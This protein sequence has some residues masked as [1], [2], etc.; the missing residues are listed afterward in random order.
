MNN[1]N[2]T[3]N[4]IKQD[5][6]KERKIIIRVAILFFLLLL[7]SVVLTALV[8]FSFTVNTFFPTPEEKLSDIEI[9]KTVF[10]EHAYFIPDYDEMDEAALKAYAAGS[11]NK[12]TVYYTDEEYA[13]IEAENA[14]KYTGIGVDV[15]ETSV[16]YN[17]KET[18]VLEITGIHPGSPAE[19]GGLKIGDLIY[20]VHLGGNTEYVDKIGK[21][22]IVRLIRGETGVPITVGYLVA[23]GESYLLQHVGLI[24]ETV[25]TV[26][27]TYTVS[28][29]DASVGIVKI[30]RFNQTTP[31][32]LCNAMDSLMAQGVDKVVFDLRNNG[33]GELNSV[34][35]C[36]SYFV[37]SADTILI[38]KNNQG[39]E[40]K[41]AGYFLYAE[42]KS[43]LTEDIG[44]YRNLQY[45]VLVN[46]KTASAAELFTAVLR[47]YD[48]A[49]IVGTKTFGKGSYQTYVDLSQYGMDGVLKVTSGLYYPPCDIGY[50]GVGITPDLT[51]ILNADVNINTATEL[52][53]NQLICAVGLLVVPPQDPSVTE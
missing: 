3:N 24:R 37:K 28:E 10:E 27:V 12:Y 4:I 42:G 41:Y 14:G 53:D 48:L 47:D 33:G 20:S 35:A 34:R 44:K 25:K 49:K 43:V 23:D 36:A 15:T 31:E 32:Q 9:L 22:A 16:F 45:V 21:D 17:D 29:L 40:H 7:V 39:K 1:A 38:Q 6:G 30:S 52:E 19:Q 51:V 2:E 18:V 11:G 13:A 5:P 46:E 8:T 26:S 50:D